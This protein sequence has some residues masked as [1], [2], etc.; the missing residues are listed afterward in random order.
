[1]GVL[2]VQAPILGKPP[3]ESQLVR[4]YVNDRAENRIIRYRVAGYLHRVPKS[5]LAHREVRNHG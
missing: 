1:M 5:P 4:N 3:P 2:L